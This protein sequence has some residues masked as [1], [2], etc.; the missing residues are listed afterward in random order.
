LHT[1]IVMFSASD[2]AREANGVG[3]DVF[4]KKP[5]DVKTLVGTINRLLLNQL[6]MQE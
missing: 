2:L 4:L 5:D 3:A 1:P 6:S